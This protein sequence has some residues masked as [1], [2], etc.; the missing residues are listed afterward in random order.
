[1]KLNAGCGQWIMPDAVNLDAAPLPGVDVVHDLDQTP[2]PFD[3]ATFDAVE[4]WHVFEHLWEPVAFMREAWRVLKPGG[5]LFIAVPHY[6]S[7]NAF[8]DPTHKRFC[9]EE[10]WDY[11]C[12]GSA[13]N[14]QFGGAYSAGRDYEKVSVIH[15]K[16]EIHD[17]LHATLRR[18][19]E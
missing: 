11:W 9:T 17:D 16:D 10:T 2:W 5:L 19:A 18:P 6:Q 15:I 1:M 4:A 3:A 14:A 8:T 12:L 7:R 13:L